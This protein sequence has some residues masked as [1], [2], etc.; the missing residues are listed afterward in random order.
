MGRIVQFSLDY[1]EQHGRA[2]FDSELW[3]A[4]QDAFGEE[5]LEEGIWMAR[6][7]VRRNV[8]SAFAKLEDEDDKDAV[9]QTKL[10]GLDLPKVI[11]VPGEGG[12]IAWISTLAATREEA[13]AQ[14]LL[15]ERNIVNAMRKRD[16]WDRTLDR[17]EPA[18]NEHPDFI[19]GECVEW[20]AS[21]P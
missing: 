20:L 5:I 14:R 9:L 2:D 10:P 8:K 19:I 21:Q 4:I 17:L 6:E 12:R 15:R 11:S 1:I 18:W 7:G 13:H 3:P 16:V